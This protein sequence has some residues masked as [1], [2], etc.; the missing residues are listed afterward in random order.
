M[1]N[2]LTTQEEPGPRNP[3]DTVNPLFLTVSVPQANTAGNFGYLHKIP[4]VGNCRIVQVKA[5]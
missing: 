5:E 3:C 2:L 1:F 4:H